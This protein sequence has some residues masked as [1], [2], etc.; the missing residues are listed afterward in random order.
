MNQQEFKI[1]ITQRWDHFK[2]KSLENKMNTWMSEVRKDRSTKELDAYVV[3]DKV[4]THQVGDG[5]TMVVVVFRVEFDEKMPPD[6]KSGAKDSSVGE[7]E[8]VENNE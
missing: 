5:N 8:L 1:F 7:K 4:N 2:T 3:I 6:K